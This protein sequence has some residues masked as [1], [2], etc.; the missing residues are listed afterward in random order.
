MLLESFALYEPKFKLTSSQE[1][2]A[3]LDHVR[4][5]QKVLIKNGQAATGNMNWTV[6]NSQAQGRKLVND[7]IKLVIRSFN[8]EADACVANVKFDNVELGEK[9]IL[10]S[11][12]ACNRLGKIMSVEISGVYL[13]LKLDELHLAHEF[14]IKKQEARRKGR[15]KTGP[16]RAAR[17]AE[18]RARDSRGA[19]ENR[20]GA[21]ALHYGNARP[22]GSS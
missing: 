21:E 1:Y 6:N 16:G 14:Q 4:D 18:A 15:G 11:F 9:R 8:N 5:R 7:M 17:A 22:P 10:K 19:R 13:D 3:R 2:K 20:Q 12:E